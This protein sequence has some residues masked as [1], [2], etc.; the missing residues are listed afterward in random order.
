[1][2]ISVYITSFNKI[3]YIEQS[4]NSVLS[5]SLKPF[6]IIIIDDGSYD[7]SREIIQSYASEY[8]DLIFPIINEKNMGI[9]SCR[10]K[11]LGS[12]TGDLVTFLDGDDYYFPNKL[13]L[14]YNKLKQEPNTQAVYSNFNCLDE[15]GKLIGCFSETTDRPAT[16]DIF[17]NTCTRTYNVHSGNNYI[18]EMM[19]TNCVKNI[20][21]YDE[22]LKL[23]ED[24]DFRIR[25]SKNFKYAYSSE[26]SSIYRKSSIGLSHSPPELHYR[27]QRRIMIKNKHLLLDLSK[28]DQETINRVKKKK[29]ENL[30]KIMLKNAIIEQ[31]WLF[32]LKCC[33]KLCLFYGFKKNIF[34]IL[35]C[36]S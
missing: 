36:N 27:C 5:Q 4:I 25:F 26:I 35:D 15:E 2:N 12:I 24:W 17:V 28:K 9:A 22:T 8:P 21:Y 32:Y 1:L 10:N 30:L 13:E 31:N 23:W 34:F 6:E 33:V 20:I 7:G 14:E 19:Y 18:Y 16:G 11:A 29:L 3:Q